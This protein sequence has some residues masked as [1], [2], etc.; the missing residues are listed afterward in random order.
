ML[1]PHEISEGIEAET[2]RMADL[3]DD[4]RKATVSAAQCEVAFKVKF[5]QARL[6]AK[7]T[8]SEDYG[9][10]TVNTAD[11]LAT[12]ATEAE[13]YESLLATNHVMVVRESI[14]QSHDHIEALRTLSASAR[15][16]P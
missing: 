14:R 11:D 3:I 6:N 7:A 15:N 12:V 1:T 5:A 2:D 16:A 13:R 10:I 4:L 8:R 9:R